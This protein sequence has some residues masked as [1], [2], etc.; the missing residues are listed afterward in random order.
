MITALA[1]WAEANQRH[2][3]AALARVRQALQRHVARATG[4]PAGQGSTGEVEPP[5]DTDAGALPARPALETLC[6]AFGLTSFERDVLLLAAG[7]ELDRPSA[8]C[9][10][11]R[12]AG[13]APTFSLAL[14]A[15]PQ[16][17]WSALAPSAPSGTGG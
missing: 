7:V 3:L 2:L 4:T 8:R 11:R 12:G 5:A 15:L 13:A 6:A 16:A 9:A 14:A 10:P 1:D 17:H